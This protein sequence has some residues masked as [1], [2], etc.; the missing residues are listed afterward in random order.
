MSDIK[1]NKLG[2]AVSTFSEDGTHPFR[3]EIIEK[4]LSSLLTSIKRGLA[5]V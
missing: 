3:Y 2:V 5:G 1:I 4:S